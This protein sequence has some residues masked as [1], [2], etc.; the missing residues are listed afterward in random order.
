VLLFALS[1][2]AAY[3]MMGSSGGKGSSKEAANERRW[4]R[5]S[6]ITPLDANHRKFRDDE[7]LGD[8]LK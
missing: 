8:A 1:L 4:R 3:R 6:V 7:S 2:E 5:A